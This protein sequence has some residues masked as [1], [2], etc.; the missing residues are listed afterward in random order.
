VVRKTI[1]PHELVGR[2]IEIISSKNKSHEGMKGKIVD[3]TKMTIK[4]QQ[5]KEIKTLLKSNITFKLLLTDEII[6][7]MEIIKRPEDRL[8]GK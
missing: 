4:I 8:K 1:F 2:E 7:G 6:V 3:E 5:K